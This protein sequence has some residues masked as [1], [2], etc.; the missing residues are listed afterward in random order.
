MFNFSKYYE[1]RSEYSK[2]KEP[3]KN[4]LRKVNSPAD[5][6]TG[7]HFA[8]LG[9]YKSSYTIPGDERSRTSPGHG[10]PEETVQ[11]DNIEYWVCANEEVWVEVISEFYLDKAK[12]T[13]SSRNEEIVPI[14][15]AGTGK[16]E[17]KVVVEVK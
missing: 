13:Y 10:Y 5:M 6:P 14:K 16:V 15:V 17:T 9:M 11:I 12:H 7:E 8:I 1:Y 2:P 3:Y 4:L